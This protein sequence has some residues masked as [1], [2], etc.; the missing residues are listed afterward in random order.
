MGIVV[1]VCVWMCA[2]VG[3]LV[4]RSLEQRMVGSI[5]GLTP[6]QN[7]TPQFHHTHEPTHSS[8]KTGLRQVPHLAQLRTH[9]A[10]AEGPSVRLR[11]CVFSVC[12]CVYVAFASSGA[13]VPAARPGRTRTHM[14]TPLHQH[15]QLLTPLLPQIPMKRYRWAPPRSR[16]RTSASSPT[17]PTGP[18]SSSPSSATRP[19]PRSATSARAPASRQVH[20]PYWHACVHVYVYV[21]MCVCLYTS[22]VCVS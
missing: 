13:V 10:R 22:L 18:W 15:H 6:R 3:R 9:Q 2:D 20:L 12:V 8:N 1:C 5:D 16:S 11:V 19:P 17:G 14:H 21:C 4:G 7:L